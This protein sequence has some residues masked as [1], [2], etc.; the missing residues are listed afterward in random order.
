MI[1]SHDTNMEVGHLNGQEVNT[2]W[3]EKKLYSNNNQDITDSGISPYIM[4]D[5]VY[6]YY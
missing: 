4:W 3:D 6:D 1:H 5:H 2:D